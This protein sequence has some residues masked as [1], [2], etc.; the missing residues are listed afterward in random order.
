MR[1][2]GV[3]F[4]VY[5][6]NKVGA[7][8]M[9]L[10]SLIST[11]Y[12]FAIT[13]ATSGINLASTRLV[14][15]ALGKAQ[16]RDGCKSEKNG[17]IRSIIRSCVLYSLFFGILS[18]SLLF[19]GAEFIGTRLLGDGRTVSSLKILSFT[20]V[21]ISVSSAMS[22]YFTAMRRVYKNALTQIIEQAIRIFV[23]A[24]MLTFFFAKD[25]ESA[26]LS[27]IVGSTAGELISFIFQLFMYLAEKKKPDKTVSARPDAKLIKS[28][29]LNIALPCALSTYLRSALITVEHILIPIGMQKSGESREASL[30]AYGTVQSMVFPL[31]F[32][33]SAILTSFSS[34]L[35]PEV[36]RAKGKNDD[37]AIKRIISNVFDSSLLFS[38]GAAGIMLFFAYDLGD[39]IYPN[40]DA[41]KYIRMIAPLIPIMYVDTAVDSILKGIGEQVY[42]MVVNVIDAALSVI[43]VIVLLPKYG[44]LGYIITVYFTETLN[45]TLSLT[46]LICVTNMKPKIINDLVK[47]LLCIIAS[48]LIVKSLGNSLSIFYTDGVSLVINIAL[49]LVLYALLLVL[50]G[51]VSF[52]RIRQTFVRIKKNN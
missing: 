29:L 25:I 5:I 45:T 18:S 49:T 23:S 41:G 2:I 44:I 4:N 26:C 47:P 12:G 52:G 46:R 32:F 34:I 14:S 27:I 38:I 30:A 7:E 24:L 40:T 35:I 15:E 39:V 21:P 10:F 9:G 48:S 28:K 42:T 16:N 17:H 33:P 20:L 3:S 51:A 1:G 37:A 13:L 6:S 11:V 8:A 19:F 22:G 43:L 31:I 50:M 36:S